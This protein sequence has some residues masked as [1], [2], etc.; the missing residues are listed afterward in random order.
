MKP[1]N[2][3]ELNRSFGVQAARFESKTLNFT[4]EEYLNYTV[5]RVAPCA[6]DVV[7]DVAAG[8]CVCGRSF[9]SHVQTVV[10]LD[11]TDA[12][13]QVG[14]RAA[15]S[16]GRNNLVFVRGCAE[17][18]PFLNESFSIVF[19]RLAFHHFAAP[20]RAFDEMARVLRPGGRLVLIDMEAAPE[21][22][23]LAEDELERLRDPSHLHNLSKEEMLALFSAHG[24]A[25][26]LCETTKIGQN[27]ARW[28]ALTETPADVQQTI[29]AR[30][31]EEL[32]GGAKTGFFPYEKEGE[33]C[34]DQRWVL[35]IGQK[36]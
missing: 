2:W 8:T 33:L 36:K 31:E 10:C 25:V 7:L 19:S 5:E 28:M 18:L 30:M 34:F 13:L 26:K 14:R 24:L 23:R 12:M 15:E 1:E 4:K 11:A 21:P 35:T 20:S 22:L 9:A 16:E 6:Q 3:E 29:R 17:E 32:A 27:L